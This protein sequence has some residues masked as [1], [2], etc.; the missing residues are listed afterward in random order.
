MEVHLTPEMEKIIRHK[1]ES[2]S[3]NSPQDVITEALHL[4]EQRDDLR[5]K[6]A[7]GLDSLSQGRGI[8]SDEAFGELQARHDRYKHRKQT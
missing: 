2:G 7:Q 1:L 5:Q 4:M 6:I 3:Y 8:D